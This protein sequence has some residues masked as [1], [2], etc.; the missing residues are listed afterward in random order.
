MSVPQR[1]SDLPPAAR[2]MANVIDLNT[3]KG[4]PRR[5]PYVFKVEAPELAPRPNPYVFPDAVSDPDASVR[6]RV[7]LFDFLTRG[8]PLIEPVEPSDGDPWGSLTQTLDQTDDPETV[9]AVLAEL[10]AKLEDAAQRKLERQMRIVP[11]GAIAL[12]PLC[13]AT[14]LLSAQFGLSTLAATLELSVLATWAPWVSALLA[15]PTG[16]LLSSLVL[17]RGL[18]KVRPGE[19]LRLGNLYG[20]VLVS[21]PLGWVLECEDQKRLTVPYYLAIYADT[22]RLLAHGGAV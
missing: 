2:P 8:K 11:Q 12:P 4:L 7:R 17:G 22:E 18:K 6:S 15:V 20:R 14:A 21:H 9:A 13:I 16:L 5:S 3:I 19:G 10:L 1:T